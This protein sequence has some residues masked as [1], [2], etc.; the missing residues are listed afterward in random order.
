MLLVKN[1]N[2]FLLLVKI[3]N[4]YTDKEVECEEGAKH[5]ENDEVDVPKIRLI[6]N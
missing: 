3:I 4:N 6:N 2:L 5:D 1:I